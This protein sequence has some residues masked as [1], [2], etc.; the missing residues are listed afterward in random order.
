MYACGGDL[1]QVHI[2][3]QL[4]FTATGIIILALIVAGA[5]W[6]QTAGLVKEYD[7]ILKLIGLG[8]GPFL[9]GSSASSGAVSTRLRSRR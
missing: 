3:R 9:A 7:A 4:A 6:Q 2:A 1:K 5:F 8:I